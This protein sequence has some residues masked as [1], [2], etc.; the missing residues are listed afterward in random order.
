MKKTERIGIRIT[1][2]LKK[3]LEVLAK[4]DSRSFSNYIELILI[5]HIIETDT[6]K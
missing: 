4:K 5:N 6:G 1:K 3:K 2:D